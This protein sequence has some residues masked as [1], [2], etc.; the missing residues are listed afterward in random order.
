MKL[1]H[2]SLIEEYLNGGGQQWTDGVDPDLTVAVIKYCMDSPIN[3]SILI[4]LP[5]YEDILTIRESVM[6]ELESCSK[7]PVVFTLHSQMNSQ[8]QQKVFDPV[9]AGCRKVVCFFL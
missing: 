8:D 2:A 1:N 6:T 7:K 5:G 4:F 3:G 9:P